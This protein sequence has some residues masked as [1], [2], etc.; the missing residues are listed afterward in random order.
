MKKPSGGGAS[1]LVLLIPLAALVLGVLYPLAVLLDRSLSDNGGAAAGLANYAAYFRTPGLSTSLR[2]TLA[3]GLTVSAATTLLAFA[4][5]CAFARARVAGDR[6]C[7]YLSLLPLYVPSM[8]FPVGMIY[9]FGRHGMLSGLF[10]GGGVY[11]WK[12][13]VFG[14]IV[15]ILPHATLLLTTALRG[16]DSQLYMAARTLGAS[17]WRRFRTITLPQA[18]SGLLRAFLV[19]FI[20]A[21]TD[22]GIPKVLGGDCSMLA[23]ELYMQI[24]GLQDLAMGSAI[25]VMLLIPSILAFALDVWLTPSPAGQARAGRYQKPDPAFGRDIAASLFAW[26]VVAVPV[27]IILTA[28]AGSFIAFWPYDLSFTTASYRF[29]NSVYGVQPFANSLIMAA[30]TAAIGTVA[31]FGGAYIVIRT[32]VNRGLSLLYRCLAFLSLGIPGTALGLAFVFAFNRPGGAFDAFY[33][34][35]A[36]LVFHCVIHFFAMGH[37]ISAAGLASLDARYEDAGKTLGVGRLRTFFR[38]IL[39]LRLPVALDVAFY[40]FINAMTTVSGMV[41][42]FS[43]DNAPAAV[44]MLHFTDTGNFSEAAAMGTLI[45]ASTLAARTLQGL[46][47]LWPRRAKE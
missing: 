15:F 24:I 39:P 21:I 19:S 27:V 9:L 18:R 28:V 11:G 47:G 34:T 45:L 16:I 38:V 29:E 6:A 44:A 7:R 12:G 4:L 23:T 8:F 14:E 41:F 26:G 3:V 22:F 33:G 17:P 46:P 36:F 37:L 10:G 31:V 32:G 30:A 43:P 25:G 5:A 1:S 42:I 2:N 35:R 40:F 13:I 20:L